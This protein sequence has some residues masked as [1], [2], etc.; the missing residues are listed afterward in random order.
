M[1]HEF[2][3]QS[4]DKYSDITFHESRPVGAELFHVDGQADIQTSMTKLVVAFCNFVNASKK[5]LEFVLLYES[6]CYTWGLIFIDYSVYTLLL[7]Y[8]Y[9]ILKYSLIVL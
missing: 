6:M 2:S 8:N 5:Q 9:N 1:K 7:S 4:L 3:R